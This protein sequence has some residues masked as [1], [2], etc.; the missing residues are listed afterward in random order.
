MNKIYIFFLIAISFATIGSARLSAQSLSLIAPV[1]SVQVG[2]R[3]DFP[4]RVSYR[5]SL[6]TLQFTLAFDSTKLQ[7][8]GISGEALPAF[9]TMS[10][11]SSGRIAFLWYDGATRGVRLAD[12]LA[13]FKITFIAIGT[14]GQ[15]ARVDFQNNPTRVL[16][17]NAAFQPIAVNAV[18]GSILLKNQNAVFDASKSEI[19]WGGAFPNPVSQ[20]L[21][22]KMGLKKSETF[23][24]EFFTLDGKKILTISK[25]VLANEESTILNVENLASQQYFLMI[26]KSLEKK[27]LFQQTLFKL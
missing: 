20:N 22:L 25:N 23:D 14:A 24:F 5:D 4:V 27:V 11:P 26:V 18:A 9:F 7:F 3:V 16:A 13:I 19:Y 12:S 1:G 10:Q 21:H 17:T 8:D 15:T 2:A 6:T